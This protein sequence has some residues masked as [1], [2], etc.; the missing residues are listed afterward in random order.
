M[1]KSIPK[2]QRDRLTKKQLM[3]VMKPDILGEGIALEIN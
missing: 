3:R 1:W 2:A